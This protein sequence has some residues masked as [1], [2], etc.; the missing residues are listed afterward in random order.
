[1]RLK[2]EMGMKNR[3]HRYV[4]NRPMPRHGQEHTKYNA[5]EYNILRILYYH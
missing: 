3:P 1:M 2:N 5:S 4:V